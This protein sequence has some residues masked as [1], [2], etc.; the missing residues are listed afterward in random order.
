MPTLFDARQSLYRGIL[1]Q[2]FPNVNGPT[3]DILMASINADLTDPLRM[4]ATST[5]SLVVNVGASVVSNPESDRQKSISFINNL[6]PIFSGGTITFPSASGGNITTSTGGTALLTCAPGQFC[7]V[8]MELDSSGNLVAKAG[9]AAASQALALVPTPTA[10]TLPFGFIVVSNVSGVIQPITQSNIYQFGGGSG[11]GGGGGG[12]L[13]QEVVITSGTTSVT[14][15][16]ATPQSNTSYIVLAQL[17]NITDSF[18][19]FQPVTITNKTIN[20]FTASWN[21]PVPTSHYALDYIVPPGV[22]NEQ[23]GET[24]LTA[25]Q[26]SVTITIPIA[27]SSTSYVV[28]AEMVNLVD[29]NPQFQ[30]LLITNKTTSTFTV[31]WTAG[32]QTAN[33]RIAWQTANYQ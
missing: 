6:I 3:L 1:S 26:T 13:A 16:F 29:A 5:P 21:A 19:E 8:L 10:N 7:S 4:D 11:G 27:E 2:L 15:T 9:T 18:P 20:G 28:V 31:Q 22:E 14:V 25:G 23:I 12:G 33:Y 30:P 17:V 32:T 24:T